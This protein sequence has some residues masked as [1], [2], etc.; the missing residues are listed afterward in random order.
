MCV[1]VNFD[2]Q[3]LQSMMVCAIIEIQFGIFGVYVN[4]LDW[5]RSA[6]A[7]VSLPLKSFRLQFG[8]KWVESPFREVQVDLCVQRRKEEEEVLLWGR[9]AGRD[10]VCKPPPP[11]PRPP[12]P[13]P[14]SLS[15]SR[16][17]L[18]G[19]DIP[20]LT[21]SLA[22]AMICWAAPARLQRCVRGGGSADTE[23]HSHR[24]DTKFTAPSSARGP[25]GERRGDLE[26][27]W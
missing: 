23:R 7:R 9:E 2:F 25:P 10:S 21:K 20:G 26:G 24:S 18:R 12:S 5:I 8:A 16:A 15:R 1:N 22:A 4:N 14:P 27:G 3:H 19:W 13:P 6:Q 17:A 11:P